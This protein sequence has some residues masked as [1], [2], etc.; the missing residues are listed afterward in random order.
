M[1]AVRTCAWGTVGDN[2]RRN[3]IS[4]IFLKLNTHQQQYPEAGSVNIS[5]SSSADTV[6][7]RGDCIYKTVE[8]TWK[9]HN[10]VRDSI[11]SKKLCS[12]NDNKDKMW[13]KKSIYLWT[14]RT[15]KRQRDLILISVSAGNLSVVWVPHYQDLFFL[16]SQNL[17]E[18]LRNTLPIA[19]FS[20]NLWEIFSLLH[21]QQ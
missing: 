4:L 14:A 9:A 17:Y 5:V 21:M 20:L 11:F 12:V 15:I 13:V 7:R 3:L 16:W 8:S 2:N 19:R 10:A 6:G 1:Y 18:K